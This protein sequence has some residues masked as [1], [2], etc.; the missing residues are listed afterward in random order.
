MLDEFLFQENTDESMVLVSMEAAEIKVDRLLCKYRLIEEAYELD[1]KEADLKCIAESGDIDDLSNLYLEAAEKKEEKGKGI[2]KRLWEAIASFCRKV[3]EFLFGKKIKKGPE[4]QIEAPKGFVGAVKK[5]AQF[6]KSAG[7]SFF[8]WIKKHKKGLIGAGLAAGVLAIFLNKD[9]FKKAKT[10]ET[11]E[12][13]T[14]NDINTTLATCAAAVDVCEK[15]AK[16]AAEK[17]SKPTVSVGKTE[18]AEEDKEVITITKNLIGGVNKASQAVIQLGGPIAMDGPLHTIELGTSKKEE[19]KKS[20]NNTPNPNGNRA[21][22]RA[23]KN[24]KPKK[25]PYQAKGT[26]KPAHSR[27]GGSNVRKEITT[28]DV[29]KEETEAGTKEILKYKKNDFT[30]AKAKSLFSQ[31]TKD[32]DPD[33]RADWEQDFLKA[34][35]LT[36]GNKSYNRKAAE[37]WI[38]KNLKSANREIVFEAMYDEDGNLL[39]FTYI[40]ENGNTE[41]VSLDVFFEAGLDLYD[42]YGTLFTEDF[43]DDIFDE[44]DE[45]F[46]Y[47]D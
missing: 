17:V 3:K 23:K 32:E 1:M 2:L 24:S 33:V 5:G 29:K 6:I 28:K 43:D 15:A 37:A 42:T 19:P 40:T 10:A 16:N 7:S 22:R 44:F 35:K 21:S 36:K 27:K 18:T 20:R 41:F 26:A 30:A 8:S 39:G 14:V 31:L 11:T 47:D 25:P 45:L 34:A 46:G 38:V 12:I 9:K 13:V 4:N